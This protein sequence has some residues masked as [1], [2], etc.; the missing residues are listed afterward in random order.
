MEQLKNCFE[1]KK[2]CSE[3][4]LIGLHMWTGLGEILWFDY[5]KIWL[6]V[7]TVVQIEVCIVS[8]Y[9]LVCIWYVPK[10]EIWSGSQC[11]VTQ[12]VTPTSPLLS[13]VMNTRAGSKR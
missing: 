5:S 6:D 2:N 13:H 4:N 12:T 8:T 1:T 9:K 11:E 7:D 10:Y 3:V